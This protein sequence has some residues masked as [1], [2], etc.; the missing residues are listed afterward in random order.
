MRAGAERRPGHLAPRGGGARRPRPAAAAGPHPVHPAGEEGARAGCCASPCTWWHDYLAPSLVLGLVR[1]GDGPGRAG[2][3]RAA[4]AIELSTV[5]GEEVIR[6]CARPPGPRCRWRRPGW[7]WHGP[8]FE[9]GEGAALA[10]ISRQLRV[11]GARLAPIEANS[12]SRTSPTRQRCARLDVETRA[13]V[14][15]ADQECCQSTSRTSSGRPRAGRRRALSRRPAR[16]GVTSM[17]GGRARPSRRATSAEDEPGT[18][19]AS[20]VRPGRRERRGAD[21]H[22]GSAARAAGWLAAAAGTTA[23]SG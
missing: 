6:A 16:G 7:R 17:A 4:G 20:R 13:G 12:I 14:A 9:G 10:E 23:R 2:S 15:Q 21:R 3:T 8:S 11:L 19:A 18:S 1:E 5:R 22:G